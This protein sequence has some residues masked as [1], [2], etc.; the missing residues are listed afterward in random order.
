MGHIKSG[1]SLHAVSTPAVQYASMGRQKLV[2][3]V[4][5]ELVKGSKTY[6]PFTA[7]YS[8]DAR[9]FPHYVQPLPWG[10]HMYCVAFNLC[11]I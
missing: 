7:Y 4:K 3:F 1:G 6:F 8:L 2:N 11:L 10:S 5:E 9:Q